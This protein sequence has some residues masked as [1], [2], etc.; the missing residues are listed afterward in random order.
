M[1]ARVLLTR[2]AG[3]PALRTLS[4]TSVRGTPTREEQ[5]VRLREEHFDVLVVGGGATG[6]GTALDAATRGMSTACIERGDFGCETS[7][8]ST[9]LLWAGIRYIGTGVAALFSRRLLTN[10]VA[11]LQTFASEMEMVLA[12]HRERRLML[13]TAPYLT[14]WVPIVVPVD[15][16]LQWPP[17]FGHPL[18]A[19]APALLP[20]VF[21]LYDALSWFTCPPSHTMGKV[22]STLSVC[23]QLD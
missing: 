6:A 13:E 16:W 15:R 2:H 1:L 11:T 20:A 3:S 18:F 19:I 12:A 9:K 21:K 22:H 10:P 5:I 8:R 23:P 4:T 17:V 14:K 7:A